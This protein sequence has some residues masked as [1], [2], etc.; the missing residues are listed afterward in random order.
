MMDVLTHLGS[1]INSLGVSIVG[2]F[3]GAQPILLYRKIP[4]L[5]DKS[6]I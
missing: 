1:F 4:V 2:A 3:E 5:P 6:R